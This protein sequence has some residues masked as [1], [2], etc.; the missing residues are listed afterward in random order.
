MITSFKQIKEIIEPIPADMFQPN[1]FG[2]DQDNTSNCLT[3]DDGTPK[4]NGKSCFIGH[5]NRH[6][7]PN[8]SK[9]DDDFEGRGVRQ[10]T[11]QFIHEVH[12]LNDDGANVNNYTYV[13][14]YNEPEIKDRVMHMIEDGIKWEESK[15]Q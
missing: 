7:N 1:W 6:F 12:G 9:A 11:K 15:A 3:N 13:N 2:W 14:G 5:I 4:D 8:N 10:L